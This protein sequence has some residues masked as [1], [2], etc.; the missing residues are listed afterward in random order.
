MYGQKD[1]LIDRR[2]D[3]DEQPTTTHVIR[4]GSNELLL[5]VLIAYTTCT[6]VPTN[7]QTDL[8]RTYVCTDRRQF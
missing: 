4:T 7:E 8:R 1:Q 6:D 5:L 3:D 2:F